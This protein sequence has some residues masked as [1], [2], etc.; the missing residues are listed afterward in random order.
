MSLFLVRKDT[1]M[2][3]LK[4]YEVKP[5]YVKYQSAFQKHLFFSDGDKVGRKYIGII[6]KIKGFKYF[7]PLSSFKPKHKKWMKVLNFSR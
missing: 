7:A 5:N 4:I 2:S 3:G 6:W 1:H